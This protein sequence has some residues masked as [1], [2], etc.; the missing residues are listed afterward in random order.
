M[1]LEKNHSTETATIKFTDKIISALDSNKYPACFFI[2]LSKTFDT[3]DHDIL[4]HKLK[5]MALIIPL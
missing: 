4:L 1:A 2:D 5:N 3:I